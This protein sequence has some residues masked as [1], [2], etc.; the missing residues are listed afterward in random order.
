MRT[1]QKWADNLIS[2]GYEKEAA[3]IMEFAVSTNTDVSNTYYR[4]AD[5]WISQ[6]ES[7]RVE[8]LIRTAEGLRSSNRNT[9]VRHLK[10]ICGQS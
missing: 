8:R 9:I 5:Y 4:L 3:V 7:F 2:A 1:L 6:G 10:E